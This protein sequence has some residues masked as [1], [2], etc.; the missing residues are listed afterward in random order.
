MDGCVCVVYEEYKKM[1]MKKERDTCK[2][3]VCGELICGYLNTIDH[4]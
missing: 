2:V 3:N 1:T 4:G